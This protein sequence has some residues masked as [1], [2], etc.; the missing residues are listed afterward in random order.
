MQKNN[1]LTI[2]I[3]LLIVPLVLR[4]QV[5]LPQLIT[6]HMVLQRGVVNPIWGWAAPAEKIV[7]TFNG[8]TYKATAA[9]DGSWQV[10]LPDM[11]AG[12]PYTLDIRGKNHLVVSDILIG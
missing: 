9:A 11:R 1:P 3:L 4:A 2:A 6:D 8:H 12:G 5:R 10:H 7:L